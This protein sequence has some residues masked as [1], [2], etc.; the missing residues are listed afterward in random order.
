MCGRK[1]TTK[2]AFSFP[3][4]GLV[5]WMGT[6]CIVTPDSRAKDFKQLLSAFHYSLNV[7][8]SLFINVQDLFLQTS[9]AIK[10][11]GHQVVPDVC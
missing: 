7:T 5:R 9:A 3:S 6:R 10:V 2:R 11:E 4:N 1:H 8:A